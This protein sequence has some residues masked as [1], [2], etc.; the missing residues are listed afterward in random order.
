MYMYMYMYIFVY[1]RYMYIPYRSNDYCTV[2]VQA[3][4]FLVAPLYVR[5]M[6]IHIS[7]CASVHYVCACATVVQHIHVQSVRKLI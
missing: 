5:T 2:I 6:Y 3:G 1:Y 7:A 4:I